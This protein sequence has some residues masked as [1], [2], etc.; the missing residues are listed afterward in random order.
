MKFEDIKDQDSLD[1]V[2]ATSIKTAVEGLQSKNDEILGK[3]AKAKSSMIPDGVDI[4]ALQKASADLKA[5]QDGKLEEQGEYK[6][7]LETSK[8]Q[9]QADMK[10]QTDAL[11]AANSELKHL[12]VNQGL[13]TALSTNN[14]NPVL[15]DS[16]VMLLSGNVAMIE[17]NGKRV[18][19]VG[20]LSLDDYVKNWVNSDIGKNF[21]LAPANGGGGSQGNSSGGTVDENAKIFSSD[22][23]N[24][25]AQAQLSKSDPDAYKALNEKFP[26]KPEPARQAAS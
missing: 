16:A 17:E 7:L 19:R 15:L 2:I 8:E 22:G 21:A 6:K 12:M 4:E 18:A 11:E 24:L 10:K 25:T 20:D 3:L 26:V 1:A 13:S 23:W 14:V 5:L 9:H